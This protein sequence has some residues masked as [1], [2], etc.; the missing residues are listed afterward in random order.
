MRALAILGM[1]ALSCAGCA[2]EAGESGDDSG[3]DEETDEAAAPSHSF[4]SAFSM[5]SLKLSVQS[6]PSEQSDRGVGA[7]TS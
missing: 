5:Q 3:G 1:V 6:P 4:T 2:R 7:A